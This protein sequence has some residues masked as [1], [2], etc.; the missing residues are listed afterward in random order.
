MAHKLKLATATLAGCFGC[1]MS[2]LDL[3]ERI[4][5]L[6]EHIELVRSPLSDSRKRGRYDVC[7]VEGGLCNVENVQVLRDLRARSDV[8][9]AVG[10]CALYGGIPALRNRYALQACL[11]EAYVEGSGT[12]DGQIPDSHELPKLLPHVIPIHSVVPID[13]SIP[14]CPP[15]AEAFWTI[16]TQLI[17][18]E[19]LSLPESLVRYD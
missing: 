19:P 12:V 16:F 4:I 14:G 5:E 17:N 9:V 1:H 8:L 3:D 6:A 7:L 11:T 13:F 18:E 2:L 15:P 10:A